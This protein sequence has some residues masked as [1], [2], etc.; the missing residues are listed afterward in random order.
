MLTCPKCE[1]E[2]ELG[3]IFCH[4]CGNKLDLSQIKAP[5]HG[6]KRLKKRGQANP[7]KILR[8]ALDA[9]VL[10]LIVW[11]LYLLIQVPPDKIPKPTE[12]AKKALDKRRGSLEMM[13]M[14]HNPSSVNVTP[15]EF[16]AYLDNLTAKQAQGGGAS[17]KPESLRAVFGDG[18]ITIIFRGEIKL[19][20]FD[21]KLFVSYTGV[22]VIKG[23]QF[24][25]QPVA[26]RIGDLPLHPWI[27][28]NT[29][30]V[31]GWYRSMFGGLTDDQRRLESLDSITIKP[32]YATLSYPGSK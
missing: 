7:K 24:Q 31:T 12:Q 20:G 16:N 32:E 5:G 13:V 21:K 1:Y 14:K 15:D 17:V 10:G 4:Q 11:A 19:A 22:P 23:G 29:P 9:L 2:N 26:G 30:L 8:L 18:V 27:L 25:F 6:G 3:R 28:E